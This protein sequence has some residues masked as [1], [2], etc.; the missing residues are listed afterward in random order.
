MNMRDSVNTINTHRLFSF[1]I[2]YEKT[3]RMSLTE[4]LQSLESFNFQED[5]RCPSECIIRNVLYCYSL[6][7]R[8]FY[9]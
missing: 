2:I 5:A 4:S 8:F 1:Q 3:C 6:E 7:K 9:K